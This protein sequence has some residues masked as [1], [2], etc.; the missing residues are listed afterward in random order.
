[1]PDHAG[2]LRTLVFFRETGVSSFQPWVHPEIGHVS[3]AKQLCPSWWIHIDPTI[4][5]L[6]LTVVH[7]D[8]VA[9]WI[10]EWTAVE[11]RRRRKLRKPRWLFGFRSCASF[12]SY[13]IGLD[14]F[15]LT[16]WQLF[17]GI[18]KHKI[19]EVIHA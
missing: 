9:T 6:G 10:D 11:I 2:A 16:A 12:I 5:K 18:Q 15:Y 17:K 7:N 4:K 3:I 13:S 14:G 8:Q 1:M 19:G